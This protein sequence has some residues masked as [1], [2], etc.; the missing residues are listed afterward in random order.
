MLCSQLSRAD[1]R[2]LRK[3]PDI[4]ERYQVFWESPGNLKPRM[5][6]KDNVRLA[7]NG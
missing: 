4:T 1:I 2:A 7:V 3:A 5:G 6:D